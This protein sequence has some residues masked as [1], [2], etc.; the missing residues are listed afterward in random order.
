MPTYNSVGVCLTCF[1]RFPTTTCS[2]NSKPY[3]VVCST[4]ALLKMLLL[5]TIAPI[6]NYLF[7]QLKTS[8]R[9]LVA[10][11][12]NIFIAHLYNFNFHYSLQQIVLES[13][14]SPPEKF[15]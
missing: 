13:D 6:A 8:I 2:K 12:G 11:N 5:T 1:T 7:L 15:T 3:A 14:G 10:P 4:T 9:K